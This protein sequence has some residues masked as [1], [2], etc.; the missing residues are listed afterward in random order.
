ME[1]PAS[2]DYQRA[3]A[4]L[5]RVPEFVAFRAADPGCVVS[6]VPI[7]RPDLRRI[8]AEYPGILPEPARGPVPDLARGPVPESVHGA[9]H[10][11]DY[12]P[13]RGSA[14]EAETSPEPEASAPDAPVMVA[15]HVIRADPAAVVARKMKIYVDLATGEAVR[16]LQS[17]W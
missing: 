15:V 7:T 13:G 9:A 16:V 6:L 17:Q 14:R 5:W 4:A 2:P 1:H 3:V 12:G 10:G 11:S 8:L